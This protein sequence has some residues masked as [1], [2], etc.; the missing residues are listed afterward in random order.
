MEKQ[1]PLPHTPAT[2]R[3][4]LAS[5]PA[6]WSQPATNKPLKLLVLN[7]PL[8]S[9]G[10][11]SQHKKVIILSNSRRIWDN[12]GDGAGTERRTRT[13]LTLPSQETGSQPSPAHFR[14]GLFLRMVHSGPF[15]LLM[16]NQITLLV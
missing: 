5:G 12:W 7:N 11:I 9:S 6:Q 15:E 8:L 3:L 13:G 16:G 2:L 1:F 14:L 4:C 10:V